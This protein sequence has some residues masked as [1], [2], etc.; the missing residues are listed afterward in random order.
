MADK[1]Y[2]V[3][4]KIYIEAKDD[5][6]AVDK[7]EGIIEELAGYDLRYAYVNPRDDDT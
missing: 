7:R 6:D 3:T 2:V 4:V 5:A 1:N